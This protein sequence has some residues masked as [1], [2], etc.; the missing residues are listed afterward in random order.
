MTFVPCLPCREQ[1][2]RNYQ[3]KIKTT[4]S[5]RQV[6]RPLNYPQSASYSGMHSYGGPYITGTTEPGGL[7]GTID[8]NMC[9]KQGW[10]DVIIIDPATVPVAGDITRDVLR[11]FR[12]SGPTSCILMYWDAGRFLA[13]SQGFYGQGEEVYGCRHETF[14]YETY[15]TVIANNAVLYNSVDGDAFWGSLNN[16]VWIDYA[17]NTQ[18][19]IALAELCFR[20][21][22]YS[23]VFDGILADEFCSDIQYLEGSI[24]DPASPKFGIDQQIDYVRSG[25]SSQSAWASA[26]LGGWTSHINYLRNRS[27]FSKHIVTGNCGPYPPNGS[28]VHGWMG[29]QFP[30]QPPASWQNWRTQVL[31]LVD[32]RFLNP[33]IQFITNNRFQVDFYTGLVGGLP[34]QQVIR[35]GLGTATLYDHVLYMLPHGNVDGSRGYSTDQWFEEYSVDRT[36]QV[37]FD[38]TRKG[39]MGQPLGP[40]YTTGPSNQLYARDYDHGRVVV[41]PT[42]GNLA[43][44]APGYIRIHGTHDNDG[45][46]ITQVKNRDAVFLIKPY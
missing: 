40:Y 34:I 4:L 17:K 27:N 41:N 36:G 25:Y 12:A 2:R 23:E 8:E 15:Q 19:P 31:D 22:D 29:E 7:G 3:M 37:T 18:I 1:K 20:W 26:Y 39:W 35:F 32:T 46:A 33:Q 13:C 42:F 11:L 44:T 21:G 38:N 24:T 16:P 10:Y 28:L 9:E 5:K 30:D 6:N 43:Y 45:K 14:Q